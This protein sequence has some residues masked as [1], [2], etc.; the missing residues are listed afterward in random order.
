MKIY[1]KIENPIDN[2]ENLKR[3]V[4]AYFDSKEDEDIPFYMQM[5][6]R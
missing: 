1:E 2:D 6:S 5:V 4:D 3:I